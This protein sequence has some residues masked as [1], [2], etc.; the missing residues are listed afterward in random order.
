MNME[1]KIYFRF[2][3]PSVFSGFSALK[4]LFSSKFP[5]K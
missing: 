3:L 4:S 2:L 1:I 5:A